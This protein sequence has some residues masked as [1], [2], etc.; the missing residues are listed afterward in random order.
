MAKKEDVL[1]VASKIKTPEDELRVLSELSE[2]T[3]FVILKRV[4]RRIVEINKNSAFLLNNEDPK[5]STKL[6]NLKAEVGG[7]N[8]LIKIIEGASQE[9]AKRGGE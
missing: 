7:M 1:P 6:G 4:V 2:T 9:L 5:L 8:R 3:Y